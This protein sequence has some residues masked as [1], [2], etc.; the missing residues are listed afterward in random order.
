MKHTAF[1]G[2]GE[3]EFALP[4]EQILELE[5]ITGAGFGAIYA[6]CMA[7]QFQ[8]RDLTETIRLGLIG[9]GLSPKQAS[10]LVDAYAK[11]TPILE[12]F[13]LAADI[14]EARWSGAPESEA[15][16]AEAAATGDLAAAIN[17][18]FADVKS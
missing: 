18:A 7:G 2:D 17:A 1:F 13:E 16:N 3:H 6:R 4:I 10:G 14:L 15:P 12:L 9:G 8:L 5:R 11:P